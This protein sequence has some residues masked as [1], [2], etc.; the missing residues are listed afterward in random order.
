[1][2]KEMHE[3]KQVRDIRRSQEQLIIVG[4]DDRQPY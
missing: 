4:R 2:V 3:I 1:M